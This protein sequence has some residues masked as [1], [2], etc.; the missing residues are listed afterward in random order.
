MLTV[1]EAA[2]LAG[3]TEETVR[4]WVRAAVCRAAAT[5]R[6]CSS[7]REDVERLAGPAAL[8]LPRDVADVVAAAPPPD[9]VAALRRSRRGTA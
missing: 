2:A 3:V 7:F 1:S 9:W 5:A 4:R 6:A 8:P